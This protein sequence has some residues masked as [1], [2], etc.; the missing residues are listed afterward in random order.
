VFLSIVIPCYNEEKRINFLLKALEE[1]Y[2]KN[3]FK[4]EYI[5]VDDGSVDRTVTIID[6]NSIIQ[7]L[8]AKGECIVYVKKTNSGKGDALKTGVSLAKGDFILT[9]DADIATHPIDTVNWLKMENGKFDNS[10]IYIGSREL[11]ESKISSGILRRFTGKIFNL[12]VRFYT[13]LDLKDTQCGFKLYPALIAKEI[14][15]ELVNTGWAH[16]IELLYRA[17]LKGYQIKEM[18]ITWN[19]VEGSKISVLKDSFRM[20]IETIKIRR[21]LKK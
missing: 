15:K 10:I 6:S 9:M 4:T 8:K 11:S 1:F 16:D 17:N 21:L 14:F 7:N 12:L 3:P 18:A 13:P 20:L 2:S 5:I 19:S